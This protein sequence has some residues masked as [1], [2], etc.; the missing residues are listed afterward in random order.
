MN[1]QY[2]ARVELF[3]ENAQR[4]KKAFPW[5]NVM[6]SRLAGLLYTAENKSVDED[7]IRA[8][9]ELIKENTRIF[10]PFRGNSAI[11]IA[12]LLSLSG[13]KEQQLANTLTVYDLLKDVKFRASDYLVVAAYQIAANTST[14]RYQLTVERAKMFYDSMKAKH[15]FLTGHDDY[16][17]SAMLGLSDIDVD[18]GVDRMEQLYKALKP[19]FLSGNSVQALTQILILGK[20]ASAAT[21]RVLTLKDAF[22][23]QG[24]RLD[25]EFTLASL[26]VLSLLP[27]NKETLVMDVLETFEM[28]RT[29]KGFG[30]WSIVKQELLLLSASLV[31][32]K[33]VEDVQNG[34]ITSMLSTNITN[35]VIAQQ[36]ALAGAAAAASA[37]AIASSSD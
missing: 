30:N 32:F 25:K 29:K 11:S 36:A 34:V 19:E 22:R 33:Y 10:S 1:E 31:A 20:E 12:T 14:D 6:V 16:I 24:I 18:N 26:G 7:E 8:S 9:H 2:A 35:I 5:Q 13:K 28:L 17:Y 23:A 27:S 3:A 21:D 37:A 4:V 15:P